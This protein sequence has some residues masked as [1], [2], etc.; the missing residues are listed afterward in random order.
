MTSFHIHVRKK[1]KKVCL[2]AAH[3]LDKKFGPECAQQEKEN[4]FGSF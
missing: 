3:R 1:K 2:T 4:T